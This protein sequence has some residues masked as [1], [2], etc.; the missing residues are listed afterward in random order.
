MLLARAFLDAR[1]PPADEQAEQNQPQREEDEEAV[2]AIGTGDER[3]LLLVAATGHQES[4]RVL[5]HAIAA[6]ARGV[7]IAVVRA[8]LL[9]AAVAPRDQEAV[10]VRAHRGLKGKTG[11]NRATETER[12]E[13]SEFSGSVPLVLPVETS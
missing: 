7:Q 13:N 3:A 8:V 1:L 6:D 12:S 2:P 10:G 11:R 4:V 5:D 9:G